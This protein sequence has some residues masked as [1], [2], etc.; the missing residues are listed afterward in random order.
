MVLLEIS[1][2]CVCVPSREATAASFTREAVS[3]RTPPP[4][5]NPYNSSTSLHTSLLQPASAC[6]R[7]PAVCKSAS[8]HPLHH[9]RSTPPKRWPA[10]IMG[11]EGAGQKVQLYI[12]DLTRGMAAQLSPMLLGVQVRGRGPC[13]VSALWHT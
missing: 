8:C 13:G 4:P 1:I 10:A 6:A 7:Q 9:H 12:Y 11:S 5:A 3:R 2:P